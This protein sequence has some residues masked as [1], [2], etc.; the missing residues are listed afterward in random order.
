[1]RPFYWQE[2]MH[3]FGGAGLD[4]AATWFLRNISMFKVNKIYLTKI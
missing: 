3:A 4:E 1:M 2:Q